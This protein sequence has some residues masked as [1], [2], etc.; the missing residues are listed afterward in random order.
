MLRSSCH[1]LPVWKVKSQVCS[2]YFCWPF[3]DLFL[4]IAL[5]DRLMRFHTFRTSLTKLFQ[6]WPQLLFLPSS[7]R[8]EMLSGIKYFASTPYPLPLC[9]L[10]PFCMFPGFVWVS[11]PT[12][13]EVGCQYELL[14]NGRR[15][16]GL[17]IRVGTE[18][19]CTQ[20]ERERFKGSKEKIDY[21]RDKFSWTLSLT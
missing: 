4:R 14:C 18:D 15:R 16:G 7:M 2:L 6:F 13:K 10:S 17:G 19:P 9:A 5:C 3:I 20:W 21:K 1:N 8:V 12:F 11:T